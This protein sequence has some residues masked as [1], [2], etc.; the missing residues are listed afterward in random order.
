MVTL[1]EGKNREVR[2]VFARFGWKV[3][4]L[5]RIR[6]GELTDRGLK[7]GHWRALK[8]A[9]VATLRDI[10]NGARQE[11]EVGAGKRRARNS[12]GGATR[13]GAGQARSNG[14]RVEHGAGRSGVVRRRGR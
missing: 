10:A 13:R 5:R 7:V 3:I 2:R 1:H 4:S 12:G 11:M 6:I 9:E 14:R 8:G